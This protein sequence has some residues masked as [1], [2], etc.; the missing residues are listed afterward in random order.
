TDKV[1][2]PDLPIVSRTPLDDAAGARFLIGQASDTFD[3]TF[4]DIVKGTL[5]CGSHGDYAVVC[6]NIHHNSDATLSIG[7]FWMNAVLIWTAVPRHDCREGQRHITQRP[8][9]AQNER[10]RELR[11][12]WHRRGEMYKQSLTFPEELADGERAR[13]QDHGVG[14]S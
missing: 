9:A 2:V 13:A 7:F 12:T 4:S 10:K 6:R 5:V 3:L 8:R 1:K 14:S 11:V